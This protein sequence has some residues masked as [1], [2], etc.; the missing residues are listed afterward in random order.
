MLDNYDR[1]A[2]LKEMLGEIKQAYNYEG[3]EILQDKSGHKA[4]ITPLVLNSKS[5][6]VTPYTTPH[7]GVG[8]RMEVD[9]FN[10]N[11]NSFTLFLNHKDLKTFDEIA[12]DSSLNTFNKTQ[13]LAKLFTGATVRYLTDL[14]LQ[15]AENS[16]TYL[17]HVSAHTR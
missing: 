10:S 5:A 12:K 6:V 15:E 11:S 8:L 4:F 7:S 1:Y 2:K 9:D 16:K 14:S 3:I 17:Q 13:E